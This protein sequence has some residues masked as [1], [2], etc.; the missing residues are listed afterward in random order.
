M[1]DAEAQV[2]LNDLKT[3]IGY[4]HP[5]LYRDGPALI[6]DASFLTSDGVVGTE[7]LREYLAEL[8]GPYPQ[9]SGNWGNSDFF[10][11]LRNSGATVEPGAAKLMADL[12]YITS[13][14]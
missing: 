1:A 12:E 2:F 6:P 3:L 9:I 13:K 4:D 14:L 11:E 8:L 7:E 10:A 5:E